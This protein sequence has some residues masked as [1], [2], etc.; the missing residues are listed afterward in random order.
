MHFLQN[1]TIKNL[2]HIVAIAVIFMVLGFI[3]GHVGDFLE[4]DIVQ[5]SIKDAGIWGPLIFSAVLLIT[6]IIAPLTGF[7]IVVV[8]IGAFGVVQALLLTYIVSMTGAAINFYIARRFGRDTVIRFVG[9]KG[10]EKIDKLA[11]KFEIEVLILSRLFQ[12]FL[13]EWISYAAGFTRVSFRTFFLITGIGSIPYFLILYLYA[14]HVPNLTEFFVKVALTNY[15]ILP[16][17]FVYF[18]VKK[19]I[20]GLRSKNNTSIVK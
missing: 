11:L 18:F 9:K 2:I 20:A 1:L 7:P 14:A 17:P 5:S 16:I 13:F 3:L 15:T 6:F 12:G 10:I 19:T 4:R 8:G